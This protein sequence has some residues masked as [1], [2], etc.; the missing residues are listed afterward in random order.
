[1]QRTLMFW[2]FVSVVGSP[3]FGSVVFVSPFFPSVVGSPNF[4]TCVCFTPV[5]SNSGWFT[6]LLSHAV[7]A[8]LNSLPL[9]DT[10]LTQ[11]LVLCPG[12][13]L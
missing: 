5:L 3:L 8:Q 6:T 11:V 9:W 4:S 2:Y 7:F 1:M 10:L 13:I 12:N